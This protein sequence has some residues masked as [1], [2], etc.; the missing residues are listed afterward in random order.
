LDL[1]RRRTGERR[2]ALA[3]DLRLWRTGKRLGLMRPST[4]R[5]IPFNRFAPAARASSPQGDFAR[6]ERNP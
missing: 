5:L 2:Y 1:R 6:R 3:R 4:A